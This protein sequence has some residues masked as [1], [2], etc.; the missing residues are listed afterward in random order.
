LVSG[1]TQ[2]RPDFF[3]VV[4][5]VSGGTVRRFRTPRRLA[6]PSRE[7]AVNSPLPRR[8]NETLAS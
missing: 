4:S 6:A 7:I 5:T 1:R 8:E 3:H 2:V